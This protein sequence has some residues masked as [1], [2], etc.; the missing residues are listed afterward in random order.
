MKSS[1]IRVLAINGGTENSAHTTVLLRH[2][3]RELENSGIQTELIE[4]WGA[5]LHDCR[6]CKECLLQKNRRCVQT[7]DMGN[8]LIEK[9][10]QA[11]GILFGSPASDAEIAPEMK[12]L[13]D[14][15][16][17]VSKANDQMFRHKTGAAVVSMRRA[18]A[19]RTFDTLNHFFLMN[20]MVVPGASF[21]NAGFAKDDCDGELD[22]ECIATMEVLAK[23]LAWLLNSTRSA[24]VIPDLEEILAP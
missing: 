16:C 23:N 5:N 12:A 4:L 15:A 11:D 2:V 14:R 8:V 6:D 10:A 9:M 18:G 20:E 21:W 13:M 1:Q 24:E 7:D 22:A 3:L 17:A 19:L